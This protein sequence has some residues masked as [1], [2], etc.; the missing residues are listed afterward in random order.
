MNDDFFGF[1]ISFLFVPLGYMARK[2]SD[3]FFGSGIVNLHKTVQDLGENFSIIM[4]HKEILVNPR[5]AF[6]FSYGNDL[7]GILM[8]EKLTQ[9]HYAYIYVYIYIL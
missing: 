2:I 8:A 5:R 1:V 4:Y 7:L 9:Y 3:V 6:S